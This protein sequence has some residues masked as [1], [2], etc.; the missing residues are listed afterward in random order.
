MVY[1]EY[2]KLYTT[3]NSIWN[4][5]IIYV[6]ESKLK[7]QLLTFCQEQVFVKV[8]IQEQSS[9]KFNKKSIVSKDHVE[10]RIWGY[11]TEDYEEYM[12]YDTT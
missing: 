12:C 5:Y 8:L 9:I 10:R 4:R 7:V 1:H 3:E 6:L 11:L 2:L